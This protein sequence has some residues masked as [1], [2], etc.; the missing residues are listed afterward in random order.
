MNYDG[1]VNTSEIEENIRE[2]LSNFTPDTFIYDLLGAYGTSNASITRLQ[3]GSRNLSKNAGEILWKKNLFFKE[4]KK[5]ELHKAFDQATH[6]E[7]VIKQSPRFIIVSDYKTILALDTKTTDKLDI[8]INELDEN[9]DFFLPLAGFEKA[10]LHK[11][12]EADIKAAERMAKIYDEICLHN[13]CMR[14]RDAAALNVFLSRLLFCFFAESTHIFKQNLFTDTIAK[15]TLENGSDLHQYFSELFEVLNT[16]EKEGSLYPKHLKVFPYVNGGLFKDKYKIPKFSQ[17]LRKMIIECGKMDW[18]AINPDI[19]G[20]MIQAV[21]DPSQRSSLGMHYT[22]VTNIMKVIQPLFLDDLYQEVER[23]KTDKNKLNKLYKRLRNIRIFDPACGSGNFLII[24]YKELRK[25][26]MHLLKYLE[27]MGMHPTFLSQIQL[28]QFYGIEIDGFACEIAKLS[29]WLAEHQM[30]IVF[31]NTFGKK[32]PS[33]PLKE[34]GHIVCGNATRLDWEKI[35]PDDQKLSETYILGNPPY[36]GFS[37]QGLDQKDDLRFVVGSS[38][39]LDYIACWFLKAASFLDQRA[40]AFSFVSTNSICQGEQLALLWPRILD[41][42]LEIFF[43]HES[44]KWANNAKKNAAVICVIIGVGRKNEHPRFIYK[45]GVKKAVNDITPY[46]SEQKSVVLPKRSEPLS[47][48]PEMT[49][50]N[51]SKDGG[52]LF[53]NIEERKEFLRSN[54]GAEKFIRRAV[55]SY[56]YIHEIDQWCLWIGDKDVQNASRFSGIKRRL[57]A[58][59]KMRL[60]S[61]KQATKEYGKYPHRFVEVRHQELSSI[62]IPRVS[63]EK[64]EYIPIGTLNSGIIVKDSAYVI[65]DSSPWLFGFLSS[66]MHMAWVRKVAG[67]LKTDYRY[68][69]VICWN[70]FPIPSLT[71]EQRASV[72]SHALF[73]LSERAKYPEK[74]LA[75]LYDPKK[76]PQG[77]KEAHRNLDVAV[78]RCYRSKPFESDEERLGHLFKL[79]EELA[80]SEKKRKKRA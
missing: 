1:Y 12:N 71:P 38:T 34:G 44:F 16:K 40:G 19:F 30:N 37:M 23:N 42:S 29:L 78:D 54:P 61:K 36:L 26:E 48:I 3:K 7:Q 21:V 8:P 56:E 74:T 55:G 14:L 5:N 76:M 59:K 64:R 20:S 60:S 57:E 10:S 41:H 49:L 69:S 9:F 43:C 27:K 63:S 15:W 31:N 18:S 53:L 2:M 73:V 28:S 65:Y 68:S 75:E 50:G 58:V 45:D 33:L 66:R 47:K 77:L 67:R 62:I 72:K 11:E 13:S 46:L 32:A 4:V 24:A 35:C 6:R 52:Y 17:R 25:F 51:M 39:K 79:Y 80:Q 22:S 70:N